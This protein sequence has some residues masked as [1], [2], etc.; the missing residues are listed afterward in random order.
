MQLLDV[1]LAVGSLG[2]ERELSYRLG[3]SSPSSL[4]LFPSPAV[5]G[6]SVMLVQCVEA[7]VSPKVWVEVP[8]KRSEVM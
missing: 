6:D 8:P 7:A 4:F 3:P 5:C 2:L 1:E